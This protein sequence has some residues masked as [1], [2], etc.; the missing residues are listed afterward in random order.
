M[1]E[2]ESRYCAVYFGMGRFDFTLEKNIC[3]Y[4]HYWII[5]LDSN[6][7]EWSIWAICWKPTFGSKSPPEFTSCQSEGLMVSWESSLASETRIV[8]TIPRESLCRL[9]KKIDRFIHS[10]C[11]IRTNRQWN[12]PKPSLLPPP[13]SSSHRLIFFMQILLIYIAFFSN[14]FLNK[15]NIV[16][17]VLRILAALRTDIISPE[18][19]SFVHSFIYLFNPFNQNECKMMK[20]TF[21]PALFDAATVFAF[22][23]TLWMNIRI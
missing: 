13:I 5:L 4:H 2:R 14:F 6:A 9:Y 11:M 16:F 3:I 21:Y 12:L 15:K 10:M 7:F 8:G 20:E 18:L 22:V 1:T 17:V 19:H 23:V